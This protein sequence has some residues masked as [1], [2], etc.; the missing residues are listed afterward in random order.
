MKRVLIV[1]SDTLMREMTA[2]LLADVAAEVSSAKSL[3]EVKQECR[4]GA[5]DLVIMLELA[6]FFDGTEPINI[7]RPSGIR[8]PELVVFSWQHSERMVLS[9]F[10]CG[11]SQY[12]T[13]PINARRV[14]RKLCEALGLKTSL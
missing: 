2:S 1:G 7:L 12:I 8:R 13:F 5:F 6:P 14:K 9:L 11:V 4:R 10:E 3:A